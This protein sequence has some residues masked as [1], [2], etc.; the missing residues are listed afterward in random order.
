MPLDTN[1]KERAVAE[2]SSP[3][4][5]P[6]FADRRRPE[7]PPLAALGPLE[8]AA[9]AIVE[10]TQAP[11][12]IALQSILAVASVAA[13]PF[14]NVELL[15]KSA[16][17]SLFFLTVA[18]SGERKSTCDALAC[19]SLVEVERER[20]PAYLDAV[21]RLRTK[22]TGGRDAWTEDGQV[23]EAAPFYS[24]SENRAGPPLHPGIRVSDAT[25]EGI[26][27][28]LEIGIPSIA[29]MSDEGGV[30]LGGHSMKRE[31]KLR[32][33]ACLSKLWDG[34]PLDR[35]RASAPPSILYGRRASMHLMVQPGMA[36]TFVG[37]PSI[38]DQGLFSRT[39]IAWPEST[40]G[41][42]FLR[43]DEEVKL[44]GAQ[45]YIDAFNARIATMLRSRFS[46][47]P[48]APQELQPRLV[49][50]SPDARHMLVDFYNRVEAAQVAGG[51]FAG[52]SGFASKAIEQTCRIAAVQTLYGNLDTEA[53]DVETAARAVVLMEWYLSE[54]SRIFD[55]AR[56][57][58]ELHDA[59]RLR[60]WLTERHPDDLIDLRTAMR[61]GPSRLR[62]SAKMRR[63]FAIL[64]E[65]GWL[66]PAGPG[67]RMNGRASRAAFRIVRP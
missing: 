5:T 29:M 24:S 37:D 7:P 2:G 10:L 51:A 30:V 23:L 58:E 16:P 57:S 38:V 67:A 39:L 15:R 27:A 36:E 52:I 26:F 33:S 21:L 18:A 47:E 31:N 56:V 41:S 53:V 13:Q 55:G 46:T 4:P 40:I 14:A 64:V 22:Q 8:A 65:N 43:G 20:M 50:L 61:N 19:Q 28:Q 11:D 49:R 62:N 35:R 59:E 63:L 54:M 12:A 1:G 66:L 42:R 44:A 25:T 34:A 9:R 48:G 32:T 6:L 3:L 60:T 17:I 45:A